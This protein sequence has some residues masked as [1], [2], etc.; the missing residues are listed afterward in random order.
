MKIS[1]IDFS[2]RPPLSRL[3]SASSPVF[4]THFLGDNVNELY[5]AS[6]LIQSNSTELKLFVN[7]TH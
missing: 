4:S 1:F 5:P 3:Y 6:Y 2:I 7:F